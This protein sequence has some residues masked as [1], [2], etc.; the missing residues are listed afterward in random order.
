MKR[1]V[2]DLAL[3]ELENISKIYGKG[4]GRVLALDRISLSVEAGELLAVVGASGSGKSTLMNI[5][6]CLDTPSRGTYRLGGR[7]VEAM[8]DSHLSFI[9]SSKVGFV[10]QGYNLIPSLNALENVQLPL[11]YRGVTRT[12]SRHLAEEALKK[13][14]LSERGSHSPNEL[15]GGQQQRVAVARAIAARP[16]LILADEP[17]GNLDSVSGREIMSLLY[18][19]NRDGHTVIVITHDPQT[20]AE[21]K[22]RVSISDGRLTRCI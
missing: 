7:R 13:V 22:N 19:L 11:I 17:T 15:S 21:I 12:R 6:G 16:P 3:I 1:A 9:R 4:S 14:G 20:A 2:C 8:S 18:G 10:F 5:I